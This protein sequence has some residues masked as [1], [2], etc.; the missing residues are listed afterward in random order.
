MKKSKPPKK[1]LI[2]T[3]GLAFETKISNALIRDE[4][5]EYIRKLTQENA[6]DAAEMRATEIRHWLYGCP[7]PRDCAICVPSQVWPAYSYFINGR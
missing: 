5:Y 6:E 7:S 3:D 4:E 1:D 2:V